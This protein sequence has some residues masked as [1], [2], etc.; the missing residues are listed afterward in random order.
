MTKRLGLC[1]FCVLALYLPFQVVFASPIPSLKQSVSYKLLKPI[2]TAIGFRPLEIFVFD[3]ETGAPIAEAVVMIGEKGDTFENNWTRTDQNGRAFLGGFA[4]P[5]GPQTIS[6]RH[7]LYSGYTIFQTDADI[8]DIPLTPIKHTPRQTTLQGSFT[9][10]PRMKDYD[11]TLH[12]GFL[13]PF[14]DLISLI[15]FSGSKL[16][17]PYEDAYIYDRNV[18][19]PGNLII[20]TQ[21]ERWIGVFRV[22][23]S[24][25]TYG[26]PFPS[27]SRQHLI[28]L[29]GR[30]PFSALANGIINKKPMSDLL[31]LIT[32]DQF[33]LYPNVDIPEEDSSFPI[34]LSDRLTTRYQVQSNSAPRNKDALYFSL[35]AFASDPSM[36]FPLD[37][38]SSS[39]MNTIK[40]AAL[41]A[42]TDASHLPP[43]H[44]LIMT[45]NA[46][47]P[48]QTEDKRK[49]DAAI[50]GALKRP[51]ESQRHILFDRF[52][53]E[54][55]LFY[56]AGQGF[57]LRERHA[58]SSP[59][60]PQLHLSFLNIAIPASKEDRGTQHTWWTIL[61]PAAMREFQLPTLPEGLSVFPELEPQENLIW[62]VNQFGFH[63]EGQA[64]EYRA[65]DKKTFS[66]QLTHFSRNQFTIIRAAP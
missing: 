19:V 65:L 15:N 48:Q 1:F 50:T 27:G 53:N 59:V 31:N 5:E 56:Q 8:I 54:I 22:L 60:E 24:K 47:L 58:K 64:F 57:S 21:K 40:R 33:G 11:N 44:Q 29:A 52:L 49:L 63:Q 43:L 41:S 16:M 26:M 6:A 51:T 37:F 36:V 4:L 34:E 30:L 25:P 62:V 17:A 61:A 20:P 10:W 9:N 66:D 35:N 28:A 46:D 23:F 38:K 45:L 14:I 3:E 32:L 42:M 18:K 13:L 7:P 12:V 2:Y 55:D 39:R